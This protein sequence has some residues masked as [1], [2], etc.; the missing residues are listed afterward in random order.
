MNNK[1]HKTA[2]KTILCTIFVSPAH[3]SALFFDIINRGCTQAGDKFAQDAFGFLKS[4]RLYNYRQNECQCFRCIVYSFLDFVGCTIF[5]AFCRPIFYTFDQRW[6]LVTL[7]YNFHL[8]SRP[9]RS[10]TPIFCIVSRVDK[11]YI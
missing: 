8:V 5:K 4:L 3:T 7:R 6:C 1:T 2:Y 9:T 10:Q 11:R